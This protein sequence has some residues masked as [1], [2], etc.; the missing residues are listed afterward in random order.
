MWAVGVF[1]EVTGLVPVFGSPWK[2]NISQ[3]TVVRLF[4]A[5]DTNYSAVTNKTQESTAQVLH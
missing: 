2:E 1:Y 4:D 3:E 5:A